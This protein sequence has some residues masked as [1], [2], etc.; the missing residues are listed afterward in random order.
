MLSVVIPTLNEAAALPGTIA[1]TLRAAEGQPL[2]V[3]VSDCDSTDRTARIAL[4]LGTTLVRGGRGRAQAMNLG[5]AAARGEHLLFLHA[6]TILPRGFV[7]S[8]RRA[9]ARP[10]VVGGAFDFSFG[11]EGVEDRSARAVLSAVVLLNRTRFR[12]TRAFYGDQ[13][14]FVRADLF[15]RMGGFPEVRL[16]EDARF[17]RALAR[18]GRTAIL[19]P[20]IITSPR[21]FLDHGPMRQALM[22]VVLAS[23]EC[24]DLCPQHLWEAYNRWNHQNHRQT[25]AASCASAITH[26][27]SSCHP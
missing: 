17:S 6:D 22:D 2:E 15:R 14:I 4:E 1:H 3:I 25:P 11:L 24:L 9:M 7:R 20:A 26:T 27:T 13:G 19:R 16:L 5:A 21:R 8:I 12:L 23:C 18:H 10:G